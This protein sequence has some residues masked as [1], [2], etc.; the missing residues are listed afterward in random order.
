MVPA[1]MRTDGTRDDRMRHYDAVVVVS[2]GGPQGPDDVLPF[3][4]RVTRGRGVPDERLEEVAAHYRLFDGIS[5]ITAQA[6]A[7]VGCLEAELRAAGRDLPVYLGNRNW[8]PL[9]GDTIRQMATDGV[10]RAAVFVTSAFSSYPGCRQYRQDIARARQEAGP[11][12]PEI[13]KLRVF[14]NHPGFVEP[15][16]TRLR[17]ALAAVPK[18]RRAAAHVA[19]TAHSVPTAMAET[20]DYVEQLTE[21]CRLVAG[22][23]G[24]P[25]WT[26]AYQS[27][28]GPPHVPWLEPDIAPHLEELH[29]RGVRDVVVVPVGFVSDHLEVL[30]DLDVEAARTATGL[31]LNMVRAATVGADP[32]FVR[33][34]RELV[35]ERETA[36][37]PRTAIGRYPAYHDVCP[38]DCC[39]EHPAGTTQPAG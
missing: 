8:H 35:E 39:P 28:S 29:Q 21:T 4:R 34:I 33:M 24:D 9:L 37:Q 10:R 3:L 16:A 25:A 36:A 7:L 27:R 30:Y 12:A 13:D 6:R 2:F 1:R 14:Y 5:P 26:L 22:R 18:S 19:F 38:R 11:A 17:V 23:A 32:R 15:Q 20:S 31:G